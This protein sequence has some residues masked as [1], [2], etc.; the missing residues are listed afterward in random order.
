MQNFTCVSS[1]VLFLNNTVIPHLRAVERL[2]NIRNKAK[3]FCLIVILLLTLSGTLSL[4]ACPQADL[5]DDCVVN[6]LDYAILAEQ[7]LR[8]ESLDSIDGIAGINV[9]DI[10]LM[11]QFWLDWDEYVIINEIGASNDD[12]LT[13]LDGNSSD[14]I[15]LYNPTSAAIDLEGWVLTTDQDHINT[16]TFPDVEI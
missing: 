8:P 14:W 13:D 15:E 10:A 6:L 12:T 2:G 1:P 16:W 3:L 4:A 11:A 7:W 5:N 9:G